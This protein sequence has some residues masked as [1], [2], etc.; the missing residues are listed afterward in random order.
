MGRNH[1]REDRELDRLRRECRELKATN[2]SL[3]RQVKKLSRGYYKYLNE[4]DDSKE[5]A[6]EVVEKVV[7]KTCFDCGTGDYKEIIV[8]TRRW[9][10]CQNCGKKGKVTILNARQAKKKKTY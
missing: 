5:E 7:K 2:K 8:G 4:E 6:L 9:R 3:L 1:D 10:Q